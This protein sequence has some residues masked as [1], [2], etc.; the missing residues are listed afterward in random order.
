MVAI[1]GPNGAGKS[2]FYSS[3][4]SLA[5]RVFVNADVLAAELGLGP[6]EAA[7]LAENL[8]QTLLAAK[9][10]F[11]FET[12]FSDPEG[13][14]L[15]FLEKAVEVGYQVTLCYIGLSSAEA[16]QERVAMRVSQGGHDIPDDKLE[17]RFPRTLEN[18]LKAIRRLPEVRV[19]DN[20]DLRSPYRLVATFHSGKLTNQNPPLPDWLSSLVSEPETEGPSRNS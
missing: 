10:S 18:L 15:A 9:E 2:T 19:Y 5:N 3:Q 11:I 13:A 14:K 8:R 4:L 6:Y 12:V 17:A 7:E 16:S 20:S 1:A